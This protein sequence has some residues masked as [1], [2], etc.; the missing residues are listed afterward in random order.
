MTFGGEEWDR[1][2]ASETGSRFYQLSQ[3]N[4][5]RILSIWSQ[6]DLKSDASQTRP[7]T[8]TPAALAFGLNSGPNQDR[9]APFGGDEAGPPAS[10]PIRRLAM[11]G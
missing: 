2:A 4:F 7:P 9:K 10:Q 1:L 5:G 6:I 8:Q 11:G 3:K